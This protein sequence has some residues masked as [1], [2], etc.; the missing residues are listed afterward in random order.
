MRSTSLIKRCFLVFI[1]TSISC[2]GAAADET[3]IL[4]ITVTGAKPNIGQAVLT[5]FT[6]SDNCLKQPA[7]SEAKLI[8]NEGGAVFQLGQLKAGVYAV[9]IYYDENGDGKLNT[10]MFGIPKELVGFSN[11]V[12]GVFGPPSFKKTSF[13]HSDSNRL[14][15]RL[16]KAK[17]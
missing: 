15:I 12:K 6:S 10:G 3:H 5:L 1:L 11:N 8:N 17:D 16:G 13:M 2:V 4:T 9:S 14:N 7:V